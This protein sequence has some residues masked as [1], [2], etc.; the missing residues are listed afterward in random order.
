MPSSRNIQLVKET[1]DKVQKA[2]ALFF[3]DY[4]GLTHKQLEELRSLLRE[5]NSEISIVK[6]TLMNLALSVKNIEAKERFH[7][8]LAALF[9]Y[10]DSLAVAKVL[11]TFFK[12]H[13][14]PKIKFGVF[15]E[16]I[17]EEK[18][19]IQLALLSSKEV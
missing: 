8:P 19:V 13:N 12:K 4:Q 5:T 11:Y 10:S 17:I 7:G 9:S 18:D 16:K 14:L 6:N 2:T 3:V 15:E 1:N